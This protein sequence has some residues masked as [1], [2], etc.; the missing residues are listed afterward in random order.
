M[1]AQ[2]DVYIS[3]NFLIAVCQ[4]GLLQL[5]NPLI[6]YKLRISLAFCRDATHLIQRGACCLN[7]AFGVQHV[8]GR[9]RNRLLFD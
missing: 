8:V 7:H 9:K 4:G 1:G 6:T 3:D 5:S 2:A